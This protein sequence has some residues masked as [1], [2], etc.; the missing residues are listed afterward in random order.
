MVLSLASSKAEANREVQ[1]QGAGSDPVSDI[2][3]KRP[4][5]RA[6]AHADPIADSQIE[7]IAIVEGVARVH[8]RGGSQVAGKPPGGLRAG[9]CEVAP[10]DDGSALRHADRLVAIAT[11][12]L[13]ATGPEQERRRYPEAGIGEH[14]ASF[15]AGAVVEPPPEGDQHVHLAGCPDEILG[16]HAGKARTD[17]D[18][19]EH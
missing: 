16:R 4:Y 5:G 10:A 13:V 11:H 17:A 15:G 7:G 18:R 12:G 2:S 8:E 3:A 19:T 14:D 6:P 9:D 1:P